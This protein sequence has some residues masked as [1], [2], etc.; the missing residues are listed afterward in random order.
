MT[1]GEQQI[2][3]A[4]GA[5][6]KHLDEDD[7]Q[8]VLAWIDDKERAAQTHGAATAVGS[9]FATSFGMF[10]GIVSSIGAIFVTCAYLGGAFEHAP[11]GCPVCPAVTPCATLVPLDWRPGMA[12]DATSH[13][14]VPG[15]RYAETE[16][17]QCVAI[18][19]AVLCTP[20]RVP[21]ALPPQVI[22]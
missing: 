22:P 11:A 14:L 19:D 4:A 21:P 20:T 12:D 10:A 15:V 5:A 3:S 9:A 16:K 1:L 18:G 17:Q 13:T 6:L 2:A 8:A 7:R